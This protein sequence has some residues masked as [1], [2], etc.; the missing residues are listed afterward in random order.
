M[1]VHRFPEKLSGVCSYAKKGQD[2]G[3]D[4]SICRASIRSLCKTVHTSFLFLFTERSFPAVT[5]LVLAPSM[6]VP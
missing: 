3:K 6:L 1:V 2:P 5:F 4:V